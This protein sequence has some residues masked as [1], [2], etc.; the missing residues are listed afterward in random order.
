MEALRVGV[1]A[2]MMRPNRYLES[3]D[4]TTAKLS[5]RL[6]RHRSQLLREEKMRRI[7]V[8]DVFLSARQELDFLRG[9]TIGPNEKAVVGFT[10]KIGVSI[11]R[12]IVL[13]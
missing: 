13:A 7:T 3:N 4:T 8:T 5:V 10:L 6:T 9:Q 12:T 2:A 1:L 11:D